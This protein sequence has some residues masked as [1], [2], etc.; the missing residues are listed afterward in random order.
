MSGVTMYE[1]HDDV[2]KHYAALTGLDSA[3]ANCT[4]TLQNGLLCFVL[5]S[6]NTPFTPFLVFYR[7]T[8]EK[9]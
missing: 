2:L 4:Q 9:P 1:N 7:E 3:N 8:T 5:L 6:Q